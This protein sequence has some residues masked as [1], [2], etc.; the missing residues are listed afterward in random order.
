MYTSV[1]RGAT[2]TAM[3]QFVAAAQTPQ[4]AGKQ[5]LI[6]AALRVCARDGI[7]LSSLGLR[8]LAREAGL[9]HNTFYRHFENIEELAEAAASEIAARIMAGMKDVRARSEKHADATVGAVEYFLDFVQR[10]PEAFI[11]GLRELHGGPPRM[12][13]IFHKVVDGI[14]R[15]SVEQITGMNLAPGLSRETLLQTTTPIAHYMFYRARDLI[16]HPG[17]RARI[18][19]EMVCFIR[20]QFFGALALQRQA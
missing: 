9:N 12:R 18:A 4:P 8:E 7:T 16:D 2:L 15:E 10:S 14:A 11:V 13:E 5:K 20:T 3:A 1:S 19:D 6:E 17:E